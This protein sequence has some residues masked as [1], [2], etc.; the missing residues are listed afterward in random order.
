VALACLALAP[1]AAARDSLAPPGAGDRWLPCE[2]WV[3]FHWLPFDEARLLGLLRL[4]EPQLRAY[5]RDD[6]EH[7]L[8]QLAAARGYTTDALADALVAPRAGAGAGTASVLRERTVRVLTQGHL[9]QHVLFHRFHQPAI[10]VRARWLFGVRPLAYRR[11]RLSGLAPGTIARHHGRDPHRLALRVISLLRRSA[12]AGV[13]GG[14]VSRTQ[15]S[16]F[17]RGQRVQLRHWLRTPIRRPGV[18]ADAP[19]P[20]GPLAGPQLLCHLF[21]GRDEAG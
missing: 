17:L 12:A 19:R 6:R 10:G 11:A 1:G 21:A 16:R 3:M 15:A 9:A 18:G 20:T 8:A 2:D 14:A 4:R 13:A 7:T 5:L